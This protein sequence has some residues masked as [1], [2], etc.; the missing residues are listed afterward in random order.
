MIT[1][2]IYE[3]MGVNSKVDIIRLVAERK[4][5]YKTDYSR[6]V[7]TDKTSGKSSNN[8]A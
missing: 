1:R 7:R 8:K 4:L 2:N 6:P 5:E 3:K